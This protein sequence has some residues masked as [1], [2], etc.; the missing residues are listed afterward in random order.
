MVWRVL[1]LAVLVGLVCGAALGQI[2]DLQLSCVRPVQIIVDDFDRDGW[3]DLAIACH[4]CNNVVVV[5][6]LG[7]E[8]QECKAF[9]PD[10]GK[11][12][13]LV[14]AGQADAPLSIA[15]GLFLDAV[16]PDRPLV[17]QDL[18][19]HLVVVTQFAPGIARIVP[20][21]GAVPPGACPSCPW[22]AWEISKG[23][24]TLAV[25]PGTP[26]PSYPAQVLLADFNK[27]GRPDIAVIDSLTMGGGI[28]VYLSPA[29]AL[30]PLFDAA[31]LVAP[32][33]LAAAQFVPLPQAR[34]AAGGDFNRDGHL[35]LAVAAG[36]SVK[37]LCGL[38][39]GTF[40]TGVPALVVGHLVTSLV[41][42]DLDRDGDLDLVATDPVLG[43]VNILWNAGCWTFNVIRFKAEGA[44]FAHVFDCNRDGVPDIAVAQ[45]DLD[46]ISIF[47][48]A[49]TE[50]VS[51]QQYTTAGQSD[52]C[53]HCVERFA[54]VS[55][56]LCQIHQ[57]PLGS[58]PI[59][60]ASGDFDNNGT[61]DLAVA[62][63]GF[64]A[65][66]VSGIFPVQIIYNP[67]KCRI[68]YNCNVGQTRDAPC[69]PDGTPGPCQQPSGALGGED[70]K[71]G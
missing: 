23:S 30:P 61:L 8:G 26:A 18:F 10:P 1:W 25:L 7:E 51:A 14:I 64:P 71:K 49:L 15:S 65:V 22:V 68:C 58:R 48:G 60:L 47:T 54:R 12:W 37:F 5:P 52:L 6:N 67:C 43:A 69:A 34:F 66:G 35:D 40:D 31:G 21:K 13:S 3:P 17:F 63:N 4:S 27:D 38:G 2:Q 46:R 70:G 9:A 24:A 39:D 41:A 62:N 11:A 53:P 33:L 57:L 36:G 16:P 19:P 45:K 50:L 28:F 59:G 29:G 20:L 44:Y 55:Y 42:A 32:G 56:T